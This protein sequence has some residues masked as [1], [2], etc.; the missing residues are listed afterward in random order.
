MTIKIHKDE[1]AKLEIGLKDN[2]LVSIK[3]PGDKRFSFKPA[4]KGAFVVKEV[5]DDT[6]YPDGIK[7]DKEQVQQILDL[8]SED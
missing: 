7:L 4:H 5:G 6:E 8:I 2:K 1:V 3:A